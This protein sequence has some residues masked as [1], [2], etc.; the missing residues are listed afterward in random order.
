VG[1]F[2]LAWPRS[3]RA[4]EITLKASW[5]SVES[6]KKEGTWKTS[7]GVMANGKQFDETRFTCATRL[8]NLG[9]RLKITNIRNGNSV[10]VIVSDRIGARFAKR[11]IDLSKAAF[12]AIADLRDGVIQV[13]ITEIIS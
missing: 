3:A 13:L 11:R 7:K 2:I 4:E 9:V 8:F 6:L 12:A 10:E 1:V 5:Y